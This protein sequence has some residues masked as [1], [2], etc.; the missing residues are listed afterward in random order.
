MPLQVQ[1]CCG[2][3]TGQIMRSFREHGTLAKCM[4]WLKRNILFFADLLIGAAR[5]VIL[6]FSTGR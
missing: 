3:G 6:I 2:K 5:S 4:H 1:I